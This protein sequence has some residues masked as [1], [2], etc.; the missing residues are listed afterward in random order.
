MDLIPDQFTAE[1]HAKGAKPVWAPVEVVPGETAYGSW[2][3][4]WYKTN[5]TSV[6]PFDYPADSKLLWGNFWGYLKGTSR[7]RHFL[8][9]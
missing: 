1:E 5:S 2:D 6:V 9:H 8:L 3:G 7:N 4:V